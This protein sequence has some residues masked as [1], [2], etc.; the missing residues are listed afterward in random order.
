MIKYILKRILSI[1]PVLIG[2]SIIA[3]ALGLLTPGDPASMALGLDGVSEITPELL[4]LKQ[5]ELGLDQSPIIQY[6]NWASKALQG[7]LGYSYMDD[8]SVTG[9]LLR[10]LPV[11]LKLAGYALVWIVLF[12]ILSGLCSAA[13]V[14]RFQDNMTKLITN[15][16]LSFP[17]FWLGILLIIIFGETL[18]I[19]P[20]SGYGGL[21]YMILPSMTLACADIAMTS[22]LTRSSLLTEF[23]KQYMLAADAKGISRFK[24]IFSHALPNAIT[25]IIVLIGN[26]MGGILGG[27]VIVE[28]IFALPGI[29]SLVLNAIHN[30]DYPMIQGYVI[31][32]GLVYVFITLMIDLICAGLNPKMRSGGFR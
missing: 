8:A 25:P 28:N 22:R 11:T 6:I 2:I 21:K 31:F 30:R 17:A 19:L 14:N 32:S 5:Q 24:V 1:V 15:V 27:S 26:F 29:G 18:K 9:E 3:F 4:L 7:D 16:M 23:G 20:T 12:G 13:Y 10:R